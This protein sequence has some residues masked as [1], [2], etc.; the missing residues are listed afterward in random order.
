MKTPSIIILVTG[1][2]FNFHLSRVK[3]WKRD[4]RSLPGMAY[5]LVAR[6]GVKKKAVKPRLIYGHVF[7]VLSIAMHMIA[8][9]IKMAGYCYRIRPQPF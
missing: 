9:V 1:W 6:S 5:G 8:T 2:L 7:C 4:T 3:W